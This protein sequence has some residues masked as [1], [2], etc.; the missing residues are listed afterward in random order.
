[1]Y[2]VKEGNGWLEKSMTCDE[3][4]SRHTAAR[5][6]VGD[7]F[8]KHLLGTQTLDIVERDTKIESQTFRHACDSSC[9]PQK[10]PP[11]RQILFQKMFF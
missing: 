6:Q 11:R 9:L 5:S 7:K 3:A 1:M 10:W 4:G 8:S 2:D